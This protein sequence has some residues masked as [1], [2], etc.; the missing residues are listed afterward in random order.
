MSFF[1]EENKYMG[2]NDYFKPNKMDQGDEIRIRIMG[3]P[4]VG[5][6]N[7]LEDNKPAR[8]RAREKPRVAPNP[9]KPLKE[10]SAMVIWNYD[11]QAIQIWSFSQ[12]H[13]KS[14]LESLSK[15]KGSPLL[16]DIFVSKHGEEKETRYILRPS[17]PHKAPDGAREALEAVP[18]NLYALYEGKDPF[19]DMTAGKEDLNECNV[20]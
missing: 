15:N 12:R 9:K 17:Q 18:I 16:Y 1:P 13:I 20:A 7:W 6:E 11:I 3:A 2:N 4:I 8:F 10:F 19:V 5:W 14:S